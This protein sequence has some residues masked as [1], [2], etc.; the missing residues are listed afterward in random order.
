LVPI[1]CHQYERYDGTGEPSKLRGPAIPQGSRV[2]AV[3]DTFDVLM[4]RQPH[5][6]GFPLHR[7]MAALKEEAGT[8]LDP[9]LVAAFLEIAPTAVAKFLPSYEA[10]LALPAPS[11]PSR[12]LDA[13]PAAGSEKHTDDLTPRE[14][15]VLT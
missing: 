4:S 14:L 15:Q 6:P 13:S 8:R 1:I 12:S 3:V 7:A 5:R 2:L 11:P 9:H 10:P